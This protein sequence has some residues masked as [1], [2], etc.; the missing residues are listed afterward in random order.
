[1]KRIIFYIYFIM[2]VA[3]SS[4]QEYSLS[5]LKNTMWEEYSPLSSY[6]RGM[7]YFSDTNFIQSTMYFG[8]RVNG[9]INTYKSLYYLSKTKHKTFNKSLVGKNTKGKYLVVCVRNKD[10]YVFEIKS[11]TKNELKIEYANNVVFTYK[12]IK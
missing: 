4:A 5:Q 10:L 12:K 2:C 8:G 11:I 9:K 6:S 7:I 1:M 3:S